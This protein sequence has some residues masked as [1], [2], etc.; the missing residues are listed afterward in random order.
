ME[1][2]VSINISLSSPSCKNLKFNI[3]GKMKHML[4]SVYKNVSC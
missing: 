4:V 1:H 3:D 2:K